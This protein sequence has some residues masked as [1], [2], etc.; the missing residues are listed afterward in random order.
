MHIDAHVLVY[1]FAHTSRS[2][3]RIIIMQ[4]WMFEKVQHTDFWAQW[5]ELLGHVDQI[6]WVSLRL[7][8][9]MCPRGSIADYFSSSPCSISLNCS[10]RMHILSP[11]PTPQIAVGKSMPNVLIAVLMVTVDV[12]IKIRSTKTETHCPMVDAVRARYK[13]KVIRFRFM[14]CGLVGVGKQNSGNS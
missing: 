1:I 11:K 12:T 2:T 9:E 8:F 6:H 5:T 14:W 3:G 4:G 7:C 10:P 13:E